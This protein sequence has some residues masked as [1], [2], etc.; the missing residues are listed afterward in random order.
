MINDNKSQ[1]GFSSFFIAQWKKIKN[2]FH[3]VTAKE[4]LVYCIAIVAMIAALWPMLAQG[5]TL[6]DE[7][8]NRFDRKIG[9]WTLVV[10]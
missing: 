10:S 4:M 7:L 9:F 5:V 3:Q 6:N 1:K 2:V 8:Q